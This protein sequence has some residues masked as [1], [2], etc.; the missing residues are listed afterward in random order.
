MD[1][2]FLNLILKSLGMQPQLWYN[3]PRFWPYILVL[4]Q[5][6]KSVGYS[7]IIYLAAI[8]GIDKT[9]YEAAVIDGANKWQQIRH[10]TIPHLQPLMIILTILAIGQIFHADFGLFYM[11][12]RESGVLFPVTNV[13]DTYVYRSMKNMGS[14]GM[15]AAAGLYQSLVGFVLVFAA[16][17]VVRKVNR[18]EALF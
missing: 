10:V 9:Y 6:W 5:L 18:D 13:I 2:G 16:N 15:S 8:A 12:P 1:K 17:Y 3:D 14:F 4:T 11:V 7:S